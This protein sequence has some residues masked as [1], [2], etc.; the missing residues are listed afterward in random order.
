[1]IG[2][3]IDK[4]EPRPWNIASLLLLRPFIKHGSSI[5]LTPLELHYGNQSYT[6]GIRVTVETCSRCID[7]PEDRPGWQCMILAHATE[8]N[9]GLQVSLSC[10]D[11]FTGTV[12]TAEGVVACNALAIK[13]CHISVPSSI[14]TVQSNMRSV[15]RP[16]ARIVVIMYRMQKRMSE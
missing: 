9:S 4:V 12:L 11:S 13:N 1:M 14:L 8:R 16:V 7:A 2:H 5:M 3:S 15:P 10:F 6:T